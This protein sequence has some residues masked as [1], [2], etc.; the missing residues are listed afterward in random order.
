MTEHDRE[1]TTLLDDVRTI[2][3]ILQNQDAPF[4]R[5]WK[6]MWL[7]SPAIAVAG[8]LQYFVPFFR[9][10]DFDGRLVWLWLPGFCLLSPVFFVILSR[11][12]GRTGKKFLGQGRIRH[13][14]FARFIIPPAALVLICVSSRNSAFPLEGVYLLIVSI[15]QTA[16]EQ[17]LPRGFRTV[18]LAF[19]ALGL[20]ELGLRL[21]GPEVVLVDVLMTAGAIFYAGFLFRSQDRRKA[22][23]S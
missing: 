6:G 4:P 21:A 3:D 8:L 12:I 14:L 18:P 13:L 17:A 7:V 5:V 2:K 9:D 16:I 20:V 11:E 10:L 19:F 22:G 23:S 1:L 15:W